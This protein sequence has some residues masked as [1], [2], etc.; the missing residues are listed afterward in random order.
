M[1]FLD[2]NKGARKIDLIAPGKD[3][4]EV[5]VLMEGESKILTSYD[6][7]LACV[8]HLCIA[9]GSTLEGSY[10]ASKVLLKNR[11]KRPIYIGGWCNQILIPFSS[12]DDINGIWVSL[13]YL[14]S[15]RL[16]SFNNFGDKKITTDQW[17]K[18]LADG[19][20]LRNVLHRL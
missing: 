8:R 12:L 14:E 1:V 16:E 5:F 15:H 20:E 9:N 7:C 18:H 6:H 19:I 17:R 4:G 3:I 2:F 13:D 11:Y 10:A